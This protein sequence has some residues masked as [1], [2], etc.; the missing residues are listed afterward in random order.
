[1]FFCSGGGILGLAPPAG[2]RKRAAL[3]LLLLEDS[4]GGEG[5][6]QIMADD[7]FTGT[8]GMRQTFITAQCHLWSCIVSISRRS[9]LKL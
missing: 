9:V 1:M 8:H 4:M 7:T 5:G 3:I 6:T 2:R